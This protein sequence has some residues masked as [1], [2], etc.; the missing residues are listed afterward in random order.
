MFFEKETVR[1]NRLVVEGE[2]FQFE[3]AGVRDG[4][5]KTTLERQ[6]FI[7]DLKTQAWRQ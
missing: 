4:Q 7:K 5:A 6:H 3:M 1:Y 2:G